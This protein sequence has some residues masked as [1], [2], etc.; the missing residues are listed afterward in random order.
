MENIRNSRYRERQV[1]RPAWVL[2]AG[3]AI[4]STRCL[5][6]LLLANMLGYQGAVDVIQRALQTTVLT[7]ILLSSVALFCAELFCALAIFKGKNIGRWGFVIS[8]IVVSAYL[9]SASIGLGYPELFSL[10]GESHAEIFSALL[11]QKLP[12]LLVIF[13]LFAP[14]QSRLFFRH[15]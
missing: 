8:Q 3:I 13:L 9:W 1:N 5:D 4:I 14:K 2:V 7:V 15:R 10:P 12:D 6:L 11:F